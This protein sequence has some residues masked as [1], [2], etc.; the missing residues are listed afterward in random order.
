MTEP[1]SSYTISDLLIRVAVEMGI[2]YP[3]SSGQ[4][5]AMIPIE[6]YNFYLMRMLQSFYEYLQYFNKYPW[7]YAYYIQ[8]NIRSILD[9][10]YTSKK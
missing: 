4:E 10:Y 3:G 8:S 9:F 5:K 7:F 6:T 1:T 2:A